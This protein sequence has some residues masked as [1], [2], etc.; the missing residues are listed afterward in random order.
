MLAHAILL[1][2]IVMAGEAV[3]PGNADL[4]SLAPPL[5]GLG[6]VFPLDA[7][8]VVTR[9]GWGPFRKFCSEF[10]VSDRGTMRS[11]GTHCLG[12]LGVRDPDGSGW[13]VRVEPG[14]R[15]T[16]AAPVFTM[17]RRDDGT[18]TEVTAGQ[19]GGKAPL[20]PK[21]QS[22]FEATTRAALASLGIPRQRLAPG[23]RFT[24]PEPRGWARM[25]VARLL[26]CVPE[27]RG[28][29]AGRAVVIARCAARFEDRVAGS[30]MEVSEIAGYFALDVETGLVVARAYARRRQAFSQAPGQAPHPGEW[31]V[32]TERSWTE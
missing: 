7:P 9:A 19:P 6:E 21:E 20:S 5:A 25:D 14:A 26:D 27:S 30:S 22:R 16:T 2:S 13:R 3:V 32:Q 29:L 8:I 12:T 17:L 1:P 28:V 24:L 4:L 23:T 31:V 18:V 10:H 15:G 11:A